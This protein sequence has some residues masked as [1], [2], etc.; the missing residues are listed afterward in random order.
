MMSHHRMSQITYSTS[1]HTFRPISFRWCSIARGKEQ[2]LLPLFIHHPAPNVKHTAAQCLMFEWWSPFLPIR[3]MAQMGSP[4]ELHGMKPDSHLRLPTEL[5]A[6]SLEQLFST[7]DRRTSG[8]LEDIL[9]CTGKQ[10]TGNVKLK[11][12]CYF[13]IKQ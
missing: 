12:I 9:E 2:P 5:G 8:I 7:W 3:N 6:T 1:E 4:T 13:V 10:F 11:N